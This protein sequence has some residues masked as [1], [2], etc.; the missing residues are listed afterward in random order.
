MSVR[1]QYETFTNDVVCFLSSCES[2]LLEKRQVDLHGMSK[3]NKWKENLILEKIVHSRWE[4][5]DDNQKRLLESSYQG[6]NYAPVNLLEISQN[7]FF[8]ILS[9]SIPVLEFTLFVTRNE[10]G[11]A[12][13]EHHHLNCY[14]F[15]P[16]HGIA[17]EFKWSSQITVFYRFGCHHNWLELS[18]KEREEIEINDTWSGHHVYRCQNCEYIYQTFST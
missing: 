8:H 15:E 13:K 3:M 6:Y 11:L 4:D 10:Q 7:T 17:F 16:G 18:L 1:R 14:L 9:Q 2:P 12:V 5:L